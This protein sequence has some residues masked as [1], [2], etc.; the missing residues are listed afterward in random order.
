MAV[1]CSGSDSAT[2]LRLAEASLLCTRRLVP[3]VAQTAY[4]TPVWEVLL[5][6]PF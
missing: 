2:L 4:R 3:G 6:F 1:Q 5:L